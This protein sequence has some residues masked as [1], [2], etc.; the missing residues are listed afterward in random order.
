MARTI[1]SSRCTPCS[2]PEERSCER[3]FERWRFTRGRL[4]PK[5][6][7]IGLTVLGGILIAPVM[8]PILP[9]AQA[10]AYAAKLGLKGTK[11]EVSHQ[12][13]LP[14]YFADQFGWPELVQ[15]V[16]EVYNSLPPAQ[17]A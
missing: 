16:A 3:A 11:A 6:L 4:W 14:Q 8:M 13:I 5:A 17:R 10:A 12:S 2:S 7:V 15:Q 9:P 1:T